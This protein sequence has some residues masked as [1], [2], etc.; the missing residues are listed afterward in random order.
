M[1]DGNMVLT[2]PSVVSKITDLYGHCTVSKTA[3]SGS[4]AAAAVA[5]VGDKVAAESSNSDKTRGGVSAR[6][7]AVQERRI[8]R[9]RDSSMRLNVRP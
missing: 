7:G 5:A 3:T 2:S 9:R 4:A 6:V 8:S 1:D